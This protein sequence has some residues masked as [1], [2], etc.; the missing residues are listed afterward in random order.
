MGL[1]LAWLVG[2][3]LVEYID[4]LFCISDIV[5]GFPAWLCVSYP[6]N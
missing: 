4:Q 6:L 2:V 5:V 3:P 1:T